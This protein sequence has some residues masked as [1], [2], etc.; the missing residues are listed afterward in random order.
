LNFAALDV[1]TSNADCSSICQIGIVNFH[2][3]RVVDEWSTKVNPQEYLDPFHF[4]IHSLF[5]C[6]MSLNARRVSN[7]E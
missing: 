4:T 2:E 7:T 5:Q 3:G 6:K 1:E